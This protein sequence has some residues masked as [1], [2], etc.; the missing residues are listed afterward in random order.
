MRWREACTCWCFYDAGGEI[1]RRF[2]DMSLLADVLVA[3]SGLGRKVMARSG[4]VGLHMLDRLSPYFASCHLS[5]A[6]LGVGK[7]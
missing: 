1:Q 5:P 2:V 6:L 7:R 3:I 4:V